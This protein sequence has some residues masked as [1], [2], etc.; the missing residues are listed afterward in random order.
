MSKRAQS[1][2][3]TNKPLKITNETLKLSNETLKELN[4]KY[5]ELVDIKSVEQN[6]IS[7]YDFKTNY[8]SIISYNLLKMA[9]N[10]I[11]RYDGLIRIDK[12]INNFVISNDIESGLFEFT[13][14]YCTINKLQDTFITTIYN[15]KLHYLCSNLDTKNNN[16]DNQTLL[17]KVK[18]INEKS[19]FLAFMTPQQIHPERWIHNINK[20]KLEEDAV[21]DIKMNSL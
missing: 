2:K 21:N 13:L 17:Y 9:N 18:N 10:L 6:Y 15:D 5:N 19:Y 12:Y 4:N 11:N 8:S 20:K 14:I 1:K 16:I 3:I 7:L